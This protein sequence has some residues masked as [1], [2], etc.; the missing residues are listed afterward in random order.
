M[1]DV[2]TLLHVLIT[3][4][5]TH[6]QIT[7]NYL[8]TVSC[9]I[10][11]PGNTL[12][13]NLNIVLLS[14]HPYYYYIMINFKVF[15]CLCFWYVCSVAISSER[16]CYTNHIPSFLKETVS[17]QRYYTKVKKL[18]FAKSSTCRLNHLYQLYY[19]NT[20]FVSIVTDNFP[21]CSALCR[22]VLDGNNSG[23]KC[24]VRLLNA[25]YILQQLY[26]VLYLC[27]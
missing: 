22:L 25:K 19:Q 18:V 21:E 5:H 12:G 13:I 1:Y 16:S 7:F 15:Q 14:V 10:V 8:M 26:C 11:A 24:A 6:T 2:G 23:N 27:W 20:N 17:I 4:T 3:H 9:G